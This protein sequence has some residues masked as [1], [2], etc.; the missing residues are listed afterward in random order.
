MERAVVVY[1]S[2]FGNTR[3]IAD[4]VAEGLSSRFATDIIEVGLAPTRIAEEVS[5]VV[6]GGRLLGPHRLAK[7]LEEVTSAVVAQKRHDP[8]GR[9]RVLVNHERHAD[10]PATRS[11]C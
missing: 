1:E 9:V 8:P 7:E 11:N 5:L 4:A 2:M 6:V 3:M 10:G